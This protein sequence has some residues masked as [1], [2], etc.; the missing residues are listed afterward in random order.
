MSRD[1]SAENQ[2]IQERIDW[3]LEVLRVQK[4]RSTIFMKQALEKT[5]NMQNELSSVQAQTAELRKELIAS[6]PKT[7]GV[8]V[9]RTQSQS[10]LD[11]RRHSVQLNNMSM[12]NLRAS[13]GG[14]PTREMSHLGLESSHTNYEDL[15]VLPCIKLEEEWYVLVRCIDVGTKSHQLKL[16]TMRARRIQGESHVSTSLRALTNDT[17]NV[18]DMK[19]NLTRGKG[20]CLVLDEKV[21]IL[22]LMISVSRLYDAYQNRTEDSNELFGLV[23]YQV[24]DIIQGKPIHGIDCTEQLQLFREPFFSIDRMKNFLNDA[25]PLQ[26]KTRREEAINR[27]KRHASTFDPTSTSPPNHNEKNDGSKRLYSQKIEEYLDNHVR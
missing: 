10:N 22:P 27:V 19:D 17:M 4:E 2:V 23:L 6:N 13:E 11:H 12:I 14:I 25:V 21:T 5:L 26:L 1:L 24:E 20:P 7:R 3:L 9:S 18:I 8:S 16:S 15:F